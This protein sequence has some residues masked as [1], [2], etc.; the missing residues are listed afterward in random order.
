MLTWWESRSP[1]PEGFIRW[2]A[3]QNTYTSYSVR[4]SGVIMQSLDLQLPFRPNR[5]S[6][7]RETGCTH[8]PTPPHRGL[9]H[10]HVPPPSVLVQPLWP[11]AYRFRRTLKWGWSIKS[12]EKIDQ[13]ILLPCSWVKR[14]KEET[15][16]GSVWWKWKDEPKK[17]G[18]KWNGCSYRFFTSLPW[19]SAKTYA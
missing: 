16:K 17:D 4:S 18:Q 2:A 14:K 15:M 1:E 19:N 9:K 8:P 12:T 10:Q 11:P 3:V 5:D 7:G 13:V 6:V